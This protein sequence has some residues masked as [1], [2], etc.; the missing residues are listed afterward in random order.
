[1]IGSP[2]LSSTR[3]VIVRTCCWSIDG[4]AAG[5]TA[6]ESGTCK[7]HKQVIKAHRYKKCFSYSYFW[8]NNVVIYQIFRLSE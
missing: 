7:P 2:A 5:A 3:P 1:M 6:T 8:V 4:I